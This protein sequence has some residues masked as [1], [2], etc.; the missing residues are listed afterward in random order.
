MSK[1]GEIY[2]RYWSEAEY[3]IVLHLYL[4]NRDRPRHHLCDWVIDMAQLLGRTPGAVVMRME[5]YA[6][7]DPEENKSRKGLVNITEFGARIFREWAQKR[8]A[9]NDC[10]EVLIREMEASR[11]PSLLE[12]E[13]VRLPKAFGKYELLD[14]LGEGAFGSVFSCMSTET[15]QVYAIKIIKTRSAGSEADEILGRCRREIR[16]LKTVSHPNIIRIFEDNLDEQRDFPGFVMDLADVS[17]AGHLDRCAKAAGT[18]RVRPAIPAG[19]AVR[20]LRGILDA[21]SAMHEHRPSL[22]HRDINPNN[23]LRMPT[24]TWV[25]ADFSLAKFL[26]STSFS[27][28]FATTHQGWGT[29]YYTAPEQWKDFSYSDER[30]DVFSLGVLTWELLS[31]AWPPFDR[32]HLALPERIAQVVLKATERDRE[33]RQKTV[34]AL[35]Q[36]LEAAWQ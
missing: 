25:L 9:L 20:I 15:S 32:A 34:R 5:N 28:T 3:I 30:A 12:P 33:Q 7:L 14:P 6:S 36:D 10:A 24:G 21:V 22:I 31:E 19:E 23:V 2:G 13:P 35:R 27:T 18:S 16:A 1:P 17:L 8:G 11:R 26:Q 4:K 29:A